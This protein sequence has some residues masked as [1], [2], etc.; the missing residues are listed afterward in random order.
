MT[1]VSSEKRPWILCMLECVWALPPTATACVSVAEMMAADSECARLA[2]LV[3]DPS[4][5][6]CLSVLLF[7]PVK[8][9][10]DR[11][12]RRRLYRS[13]H[14]ARYLCAVVDM[15]G[16]P[17]AHHCRRHARGLPACLYARLSVCVCVGMCV[18]VG[19]CGCWFRH[20]GIDGG[21][22]LYDQGDG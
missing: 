9:G 12:A 10:A 1:G 15:I 7:A 22:G 2:S 4:V 5:V 6:Q 18:A 13:L 16:S 8:Q 11:E 20:V 17:G 14:A 21:R 19:W 3:D